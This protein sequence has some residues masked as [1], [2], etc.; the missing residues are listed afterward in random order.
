MCLSS[1]SPVS[2]QSISFTKKQFAKNAEEKDYL[3]CI[4]V[5]HTVNTYN[6]D[7][8][9]LYTSIK[10]FVLHTQNGKEINFKFRYILLRTY[11]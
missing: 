5:R 10:D 9:I 6:T 4:V 3:D 7:V 1:E 11:K 8:H 2:L